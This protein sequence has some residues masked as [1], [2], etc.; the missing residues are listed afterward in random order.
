MGRGIKSLTLVSGVVSIIAK[1][2][3]AAQPCCNHHSFISEVVESRTRLSL[4]IFH[5]GYSV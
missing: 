4:S 2:A 5:D 3:R 1:P